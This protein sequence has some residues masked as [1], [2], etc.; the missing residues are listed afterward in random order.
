MQVKKHVIEIIW[1]AIIGVVGRLITPIPN[2]TPLTSTS[3]FAGANLP[4]SLSFLTIFITL[5][6]SDICLAFMRGYP[7]IGYFTLFNYTGFAAIVFLGS[8]FKCSKW[9][10]I[11]YVF[12]SSCGFWLWTN[13]GVW[14]TSGLYP[15]TLE[16]FMACYYFALPFLRN[17][18]I[19]DVIWSCLIFGSFYIFV[20]KKRAKDI[21]LRCFKVY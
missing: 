18:L 8:R 12:G 4:R 6:V 20:E 9:G 17:S 15:R 10:F 1:V 19:G 16:G 13:F 7:I 5:L 2:I 11:F 21:G 14:L 3:L